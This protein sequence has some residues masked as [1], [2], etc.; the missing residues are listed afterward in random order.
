SELLGD[1]L[2]ANVGTV[3]LRAAAWAATEIVSVTAPT[4]SW[5]STRVTLLM[6]TGTSVFWNVKNPGALTW[7][8]KPPVTTFGKLYAPA[9]SVKPWRERLVC[10]LVM[11]TV[12]EG[13]A[14]WLRSVTLP[15]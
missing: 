15:T 13:T 1:E 5:T 2:A 7:I 8:T 12:A 3:G 11:V 10:V 9:A 14:A 6:L 4:S